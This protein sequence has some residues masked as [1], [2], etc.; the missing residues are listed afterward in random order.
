MNNELDSYVD[1]ATLA[2]T[3]GVSRSGLYQLRKK[4]IMPCGV[5]LGRSR[6]WSVAEIQNWLQQAR[7]QKG[8]KA[9][10][11]QRS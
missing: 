1:A 9:F 8:V 11:E 6:R 5:Q 4:G 10:D 7:I 3:L 2:R